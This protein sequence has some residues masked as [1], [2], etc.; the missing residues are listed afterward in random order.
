MQRMFLATTALHEFWDLNRPILFLGRW[1]R[2]HANRAVRSTLDT[3]EVP[4]LWGKASVINAGYELCLK[5]HERLLS[6]LTEFLNTYHEQ[7]KN[8]EY[9]RK[10][11]GDWL[12]FFMHQSYDRHLTLKQAFS[13]HQ[14]DETWLLDPKQHVI[15]ITFPHGELDKSDAY[16][17]Q[18]YSQMLNTMGM[19]DF[20]VKSLAHPIPQRRT[21][22]VEEEKRLLFRLFRLYGNLYPR[23]ESLLTMTS[24]RLKNVS[25]MDLLRLWIKFRGRLILD[26]LGYAHQGTMT[27]DLKGRKEASLAMDE[28]DPFEKKLAHLAVCNMP[29][30]YLEGFRDFRHFVRNLPIRNRSVFISE[31]GSYGNDVLKF[32]RA[33]KGADTTLYTMQHGGGYG[34][35]RHNLPE[36]I[37]R[38]T[39]D[40]FLTW[41]W[42]DG[43]ST[44][45]LPHPSLCGLKKAFKIHR[46]GALMRIAQVIQNEATTKFNP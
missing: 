44:M 46:H 24:F 37:Q 40:H 33:D 38:A 20:P 22:V 10:I 8:K 27:V 15:P 7:N 41:G 34:T 17:L 29:L 4:Y 2:I 3:R 1:C 28:C 31:T 23:S 25:W 26:D 9:Y 18:Q 6:V 43:E 35:E 14:V 5:R 32:H 36:E 12:L 21:I 45:P 39:S 16:Q 30:L 19:G 11:I 13:C 42:H